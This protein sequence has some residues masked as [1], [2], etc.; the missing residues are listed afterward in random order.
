MLIVTSRKT[1][2]FSKYLT[3]NKVQFHDVQPVYNI[4]VLILEIFGKPIVIFSKHQV[5]YGL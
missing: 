5:F 3:T 1:K 2:I 4:R